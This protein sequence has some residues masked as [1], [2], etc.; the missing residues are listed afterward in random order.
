M[1]HLSDIPTRAEV[2]ALGPVK[3]IVSPN[4]EHLKYG[5]LWGQA[6][7]DAV[8]Y[9]CP[10]LMAREAWCMQEVANDPPDRCGVVRERKEGIVIV[11]MVWC[12]CS[13]LGEFECCFIDCEQNPFTKKS[14]FNEVGVGHRNDVHAC[15]SH[16]C[17]SVCLQVVFF[18]KPS[19]TLIASEYVS[20]AGGHS[21]QSLTYH[22]LLCPCV[23]V[24]R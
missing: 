20:N 18:H 19:K 9:G 7:P 23:C 3:H 1:L 14:F 21:T 10:G 4:F 24:C 17:V 8:T 15:Q 2:D 5:P 11:C 13:W 12:V 16:E 6:Y 22:P